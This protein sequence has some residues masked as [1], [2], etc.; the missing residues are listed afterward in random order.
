MD[1]I[2]SVYQK[3]KE[4]I[5]RVIVGK[6][7][8]VDML[9]VT[10]L[11]GGHLLLEDVP[12]T[13]KTMLIKSLAA[14]VDFMQPEGYQLSPEEDRAVQIMFANAYARY[15]KP[16]APVVWKEYGRSVWSKQVDGNFNPS[17]EFLSLAA[18]YYRYALE[19]CYQG[20]TAGMFC[21]YSTA[22][23][24]TDE[25]SDYG[26]WNPDGSDR[27]VTALLRNPPS[28]CSRPTNSEMNAANAMKS[29]IKYTS[30]M[31]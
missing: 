6:Q 5:A 11:C 1:Q 7:D 13:G 14:S 18:D 9:M 29:A 16:D 19:Y 21:W 31:V 17:D 27:P 25:D 20:D 10:L 28:P 4:N 30:S 22:G 3:I 23:Y 15:V 2:S 26:I 24:R 8:T 12:G